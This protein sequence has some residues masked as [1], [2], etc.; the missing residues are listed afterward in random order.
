MTEHIDTAA[1]RG[2]AGKFESDVGPH[3]DN[4]KTA[5]S[6]D[7][8]S[9]EYSNFTSVSIALAAVYVEACNFA[10]QDL[11][12][13]RQNTTDFGKALTQTANDWDKAEHAS[14]PKVN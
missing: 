14:T 8:Q 9:I 6:T 3:L 7:A 10:I 11:S 5:M 12:H 4:A 2:L 13:K 1:L